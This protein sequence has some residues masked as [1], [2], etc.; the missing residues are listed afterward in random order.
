MTV[1]NNRTLLFLEKGLQGSMVKQ[2]AVA[3]NMAN[4]NTPGYNSA[5]VNFKEQLQSAL[6]SSKKIALA[7]TKEGHIT[8]RAPL[9]KINP[10]IVKMTNTQINTDGNN[11]DIDQEMAQMAENLIYQNTAINQLNSRIGILKNVI[12]EGR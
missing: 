2:K 10:Q 4:F 7:A 5:K 6:G 8:N 9:N 3:Q 11:V 12:S 1:F